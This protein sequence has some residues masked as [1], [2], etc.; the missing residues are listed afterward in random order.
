MRLVILRSKKTPGFGRGKGD[1]LQK[2][3]T[4]YASRVI[5]NLRGEDRFCT[6]C[7]PECILCRRPYGRRFGKQI[8]AVVDFP[9]VLPYLLE[10]PSDYLPR[11]LPPHEVLIAIQ[12]QEQILLEILKEC[13]SWGTKGVIVPREGPRWISPATMKEANRICEENRVEISFPKPFCSFQPPP[14]SLLGQFRTEFHIGSPQVELTVKEGRIAGAHVHV[15]SPCG[16]TYYVARW[17][18]GRAMEPEL[19][20]EVISKRLHSYPCTASM[21]WDEEIA[22]TVLHVAGRLHNQIL[23]PYDRSWAEEE[24]DLVMTP[25]GIRL[26]RPVPIQENQ[27]N[28]ENATRA[29]L[30]RLEG[31][32]WIWLREL[33]AGEMAS[34]AAIN[35]ALILLKREGQIEMAE[36][37]VAK[38]REQ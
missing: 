12:I 31:R 9:A 29:I 28:I 35:S 32:Q 25:M 27:K 3:D 1:Y 6:V 34:P 30:K 33:R 20:F 4:R 17:L 14:G 36:G 7:H 10:K 38:V 5:G 8:V 23:E 13:R 18:V 11:N 24:Q 19:R 21:E 37:K 26:P 16:A 2:L 22:D 15:S